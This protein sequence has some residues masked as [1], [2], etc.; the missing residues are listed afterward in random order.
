MCT[1][2]ILNFKVDIAAT[3]NTI[4]V[5]DFEDIVD[6]CDPGFRIE[7]TN[8][9]INTY[10]NASVKPVGV[11]DLVC[12]RNK[13]F[14]VLQFCALDGPEFHSKLPLMGG[15]DF[16]LLNM[17]RMNVDEIHSI[18]ATAS[19]HKGTPLTEAYVK[20]TYSDVV[21]NLGSIGHPAHIKLYT[22]V[23]PA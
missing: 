20:H 12:M 22:S 17:V 5:N 19:I 18:R 16:E 2:R 21:S 3:C 11:I 4:H 13:H 1:L 9:T 10:N 6:I 15:T 23:I 14:L 8:T 7:A